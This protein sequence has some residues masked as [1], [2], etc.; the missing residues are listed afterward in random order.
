MWQGNNI[1]FHKTRKKSALSCCCHAVYC[2]ELE[3]SD[4]M[5]NKTLLINFNLLFLLKMDKQW[6]RIL[7][8]T[9]QWK[10]KHSLLLAPQLSAWALD[11]CGTHLLFWHSQ[12]FYYDASINF[13]EEPSSDSYSSYELGFS[14]YTSIEQKCSLLTQSCLF[15]W[16]FWYW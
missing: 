15:K 9:H 16:Q 7:E 11:F 2:Y 12:H 8:K 5:Q 10:C 3:I 6:I 13:P 4:T 1:A 14:C